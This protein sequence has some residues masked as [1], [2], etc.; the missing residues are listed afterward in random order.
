MIK[1]EALKNH[2]IMADIKAFMLNYG[3][4]SDYV[5]RY[6]YSKEI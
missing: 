4:V 6:Q 2:H 1:R 5:N 3:Y